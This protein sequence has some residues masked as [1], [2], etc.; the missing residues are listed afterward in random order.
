LILRVYVDGEMLHKVRKG[1]E[2]KVYTDVEGKELYEDKGLVT[3]VANEAEFTPK[4]IQTRK[5]RTKLVYAVKIKVSN[6]EGRY[7]IGMPAEVKF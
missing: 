4:V 1:D 5:E 7:K 3:W 2:V 6:Q